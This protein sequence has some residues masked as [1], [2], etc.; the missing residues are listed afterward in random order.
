MLT[1]HFVGYYGAVHTCSEP[2]CMVCFEFS[3][4]NF[5]LKHGAAQGLF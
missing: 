1:V 3:H 2:A 5:L 4:F